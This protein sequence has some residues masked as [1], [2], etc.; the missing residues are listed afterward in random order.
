MISNTCIELIAKSAHYPMVYSRRLFNHLPMTL[1]ALDQMGASNSQLHS[2]QQY[3]SQRFSNNKCEDPK[4]PIIQQFLHLQQFYLDS[5]DEYGIDTTLGNTL[6]TLMPGVAAGGFYCMTRL[7]S[8]LKSQNFSEI[9]FALACWRIYYLDVGGLKASVDKKPGSLL[10]SIAKV[11]SHYRFPAGN[12]VD[13]IVNVLALP[14]YHEQPS[15]LKNINFAIISKSV[16]SAYQMTGHF[17]LLQAVV[18]TKSLGELL[19]YLDDDELALRYFWQALVLVYL[20]TGCTLMSVAEPVEL[21]PWPKI[22]EFCC[23]SQNEHL[24]ELCWACEELAR[25]TGDINC[26]K[27]ASRQVHFNR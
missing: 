26:H 20:S 24:I 7:A 22:R 8:A 12:A 1:V 9:A 13:R 23:D 3:Y 10:R 6:P 27:V 25:I 16:V 17:T 11:T 2:S 15:Q 5:L 14:E 18:A 21:I 19:F 4:N